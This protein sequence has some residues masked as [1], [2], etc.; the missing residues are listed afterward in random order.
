M[1]NTNT[2]LNKNRQELRS[3]VIPETISY[4]LRLIAVYDRIPVRGHSKSTSRCLLSLFL[5]LSHQRVYMGCRTSRTPSPPQLGRDVIFEWLLSSK[6][7]N[8]SNKNLPLNWRNN[9]YIYTRIYANIHTGMLFTKMRYSFKKVTLH[10]H[11]DKHRT[12]AD[13]S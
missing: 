4:T 13:K 7:K 5:P 8:F 12:L 3:S 10:S 6:T 11:F 1:R 2:G 9:T